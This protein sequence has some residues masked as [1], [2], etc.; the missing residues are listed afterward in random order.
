MGYSREMV[1]TGK[2]IRGLALAA[3][4]LKT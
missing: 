4:P 2:N 1:V 3:R